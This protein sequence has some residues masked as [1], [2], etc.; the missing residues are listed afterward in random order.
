MNGTPARRL[1]AFL[2]TGLALWASAAC[3]GSPEPLNGDLEKGPSGTSGGAWPYYGGD[4]ANTKYSALDQIDRDNFADLEIAWRWKTDNL[5][6][7]PEYNMRVTPIMIDGV[8]YTT[9]GRRRF[10]AAIDAATGET[11]WL[12]RL[13]EGERGRRA[14]R[15]NSGRGV[16]YWREGDDER[17]FLVSPGY[18]LIA[19]D[20]R[21][22]RPIPEFGNDGIV[23]LFEG[24][25]RPVDGGIGSSSPPIVSRGVVILGAALL[26]GNAPPTKENA[27]GHVRGFDVRTGEQKWIFHTI[28]QPG[29]FGHDTWE[30]DSWS[31][32]GNAAVWTVLTVDQELGY[33]YL[34][35]E[36]PTGD[37]Y[38]G[39]RLGDNLFSQ[40][41]VCLNVE[42]GERVWHYQM[43][44]HGLWD[45]DPPAPPILIDVVVDGR[46]IKA[47]AQVT[48]QAF[49]YVFDRVTGEPVWPIEERP[50]AQSDV[51]GERTA[52]TQPFPT[53]PPPFDRQGVSIDDLI[54]FTP[55]LRQ[56]AIE[57]ASNY[58]LGPLFTPV[59]LID[60]EGTQGTLVLPG[61]LGG[62]NW[63]GGAADTETGILYV[64]SATSPSTH[65][66]ISDSER[67]NMRYIKGLGRRL[68]RRRGGGGPQGLPLIKPPWGRITAIDLNKGDLLWQVPNGDTPDYVKEHEALQGIDIPPTGRPDRGGLIVTKTLLI[69]GE[70]SGLF[71]V[72][73]GGGPMLRA[74]DKLT[75]EVVAEIEMPANQSGVPM[76]YMLP[77]EDAAEGEATEKQYIVVA[78]G[79]RNHPAELIALTLP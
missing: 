17:I 19:L 40:S 68:T 39:H 61:A 14:P 15:A 7:S 4:A 27:P 34:P 3:T 18:H 59:S 13:D 11:L 51:P 6:A 60:P 35:V 16:A 29:D 36:A 70:G 57:L 55:E 2:L 73:G 65:G 47:V 1:T 31:F 45:Y 42:T 43:V 30:E 72:Y 20:A 46:A 71:G 77:V 24:L 9:A 25:G 74:Y 5:G 79:A 38:G 8:L 53:K 75:G 76:T 44:H 22:G 32:T 21:T 54:D 78:I 63:P 48:K 50:V 66:L 52:P 67:S 23:D 64:A 41:L 37:Y 10:A 69:A 12:Y 28:P 33:V 26:A 49:T 62:A 58:R 56:E